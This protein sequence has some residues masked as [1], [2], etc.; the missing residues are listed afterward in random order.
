MSNSVRILRR[1]LQAWE[2][3]SI[4]FPND[5]ALKKYLDAH[6]K[7][8]RENHWVKGQRPSHIPADRPKRPYNKRPKPEVKSEPKEAPKP[9]ESLIKL[10]NFDDVGVDIDSLL[11]TDNDTDPAVALM[12]MIF[13]GNPVSRDMIK[14]AV[15]SLKQA[16]EDGKYNRGEH[17]KKRL[18]MAVDK[19][20]SKLTAPKQ[21]SDD[22][23][24]ALAEVEKAKEKAKPADLNAEFDLKDISN[25]L[26]EYYDSA[27]GNDPIDQVIAATL[28]GKKVKGKLLAQ[29]IHTLEGAIEQGYYNKGMK[30][31]EFLKAALKKMKDM[32]GSLDSIDRHVMKG[33]PNGKHVLQ[34]SLVVKK[35]K[36]IGEG[37]NGAEFVTVRDES[38]TEHQA[39]WKPMVNERDGLRDYVE[40]GTYYAREAV[41]SDVDE[42]YGGKRIVPYAFVQELEDVESGETAKGSIHEFVPNTLSTMGMMDRGV[43]AGKLGK[44]FEAQKMFFLDLITGNDDRHEGNALWAENEEYGFVPHAIDN[45]L[46]FPDGSTCRFIFAVEVPAFRQS[47]MKP[48][49]A[50]QKQLKELDLSK[51][52]ETMDK[53]K[54]LTPLA[55]VLTLARA[56]ALKN[57]PSRLHSFYKARCGVYGYEPYNTSG[58]DV[59]AEWVNADGHS[60]VEAKEITE[61]QYAQLKKLAGFE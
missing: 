23:E 24:A 3:R 14:D 56:Q 40:A 25:D 27:M 22:L 44:S 46:T 15:E 11:V 49:E 60:R 17:G 36:K 7:A 20:T 18:Q 51:L 55:K 4:E 10:E 42:V 48:N 35:R 47:V 12:A 13:D 57:D 21:E 2:R 5:G 37:V 1:F 31:K 54:D 16:I 41:V 34:K 53:M 38:G 6:P 58:D 9:S 33:T 30:G 43:D 26:S 52:A 39:V 28:N 8:K 61:E 19:L 32:L 45:G 50:T 59:I 29:A